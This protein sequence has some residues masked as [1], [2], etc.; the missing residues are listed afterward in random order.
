MKN[1]TRETIVFI[2]TDGT[3]ATLLPCENPPVVEIV[4]ENLMGYLGSLEIIRQP[5]RK[6]IFPNWEDDPKGGPY[7]VSKDIFDLLPPSAT[8]FVTPD[9]HTAM[10]NGL[11][12]PHIVRRFI[13]KSAVETLIVKQPASSASPSE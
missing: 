4:E 7:V 10:L 3:R 9:Y 5:Y 12:Q 2:R 13:V 1:L 6:V 8:E 11:N